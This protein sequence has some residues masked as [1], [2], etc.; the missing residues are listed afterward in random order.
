MVFGGGCEFCLAF[1][2]DL[3]WFSEAVPMLAC[4]VFNIGILNIFPFSAFS[5]PG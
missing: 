3:F 5:M 4:S 2:L 1:Q